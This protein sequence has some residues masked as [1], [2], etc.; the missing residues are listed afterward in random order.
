MSKN[1]IRNNPGDYPVY[2]SQTENNGILGM[3]NSY[4]YEGN[5][6]SWTTDGAKAGTVFRRRGKFSITNV[7]GLLKIKDENYI[8]FDYLF[9][10][11]SSNTPKYVA[12]G[13]GNAKLMSNV[14]ASIKIPIPSKAEQMRIA[15]ILNNFSSITEDMTKGLP[16]EIEAR[17]K[18]Y[19]YYRDRLLS[20]EKLET[21]TV[22]A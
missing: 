20:F 19:A 3:I 1:F 11:L 6:L 15:T 16:A 9:Y 12:K 21:E 5:Y 2:S 4:N 22:N 7:C 14:M 18:Q 13:M 17:S 8:D 10:I